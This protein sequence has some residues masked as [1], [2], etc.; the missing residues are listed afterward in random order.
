MMKKWFAIILVF[1]LLLPVSVTSAAAS[2]NP[3]KVFVDGKQVK[4]DVDPIMSNNN[5]L[6]QYTTVFKALGM[7]YSWDQEEKLITGYNDYLLMYI[8][9]GERVAWIN[10]KEI[11]MDTPAKVVNGRTLVPIRFIS[12]ATGAKVVWDGQQRTINITSAPEKTELTLSMRD[13]QWNDS[14]TSV[15]D[16]ESLKLI[17]KSQYYVSYESVD[18]AGYTAYPTY[19]FDGDKLYSL[20]YALELQEQSNEEYLIAIGTLYNELEE[21]FGEPYRDELYFYDASDYHEEVDRFADSI[22]AGEAELTVTWQVG[23]TEIELAAFSD[24]QGGIDL[25]L[26]LFNTK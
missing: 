20:D 25:Y 21:Q 24:E 16:N 10:N 6:V 11:K 15:M 2:T 5:T 14:V 22:A 13:H 7:N 18:V 23:Y 8:K 9:I 1:S 19:Y 3:I 17:D 4:F 12:E 26:S